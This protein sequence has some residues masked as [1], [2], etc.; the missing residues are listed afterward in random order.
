MDNLWAKDVERRK[1]KGVEQAETENNRPQ[2]GPSTE[3]QPILCITNPKVNFAVQLLCFLSRDLD[4]RR[5]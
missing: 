1:D 5:A 3:L 2:P 4:H